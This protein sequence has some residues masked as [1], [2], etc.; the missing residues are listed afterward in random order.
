MIRGSSTRHSLATET[1][2]D[3]WAEDRA[4][5]G[6]PAGPG[7]SCPGPHGAP[8]PPHTRSSPGVDNREGGATPSS[9][10]RIHVAFHG[11]WSP[12]CPWTAVPVGRDLI[13]TQELAQSQARHVACARHI[14]GSSG[15]MAGA[16]CA[17]RRGQGGGV[18]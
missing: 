15:V 17:R 10:S 18:E 8:M 1:L 13:W 4:A 5:G 12:G 6:R 14:R 9:P 7:A 16:R 3:T 2:Q 11:L